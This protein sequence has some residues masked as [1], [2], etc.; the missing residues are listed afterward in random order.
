[1][2]QSGHAPELDIRCVAPLGKV[3]SVPPHAG[4]NAERMPD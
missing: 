1:M 3:L 4:L 2:Q